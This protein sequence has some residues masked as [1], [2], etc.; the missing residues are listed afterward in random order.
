MARLLALDVG[1]KTIGVAWSDEAETLAFPGE[2]ILRQAGKKQDMAAVRQLVSD[3]LARAIVIGLPLMR[4]GSRGVQAAKV[5]DFVATL[6][7]YVRIPIILQDERLTTWDAEQALIEANVPRESRKKVIDSMAACLIL[8]SYLD[9]QNI[10][11]I[12]E[13]QED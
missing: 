13:S 3:R 12:A 2:T 9:R 6:R 4:D 7:N 11:R 8:R 1:E 5:E 10:P